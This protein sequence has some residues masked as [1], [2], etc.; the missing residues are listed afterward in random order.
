MRYQLSITKVTAWEPQSLYSINVYY[1]KNACY[2]QAAF[3][4]E[5]Y[6]TRLFDWRL[7]LIRSQVLQMWTSF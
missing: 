6:R 4:G 7:S 1:L 5:P 2:G 3:G